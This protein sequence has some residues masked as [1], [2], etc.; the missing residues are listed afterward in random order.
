MFACNNCDYFLDV[1]DGKFTSAICRKYNK[2]LERYKNM[3][4]IYT[5]C[6]QCKQENTEEFKEGENYG[7]DYKNQSRR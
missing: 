1:S 6:E 2:M 4:G 5:P 3:Y 7:T